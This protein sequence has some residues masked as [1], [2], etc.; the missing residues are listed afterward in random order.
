MGARPGATGAQVLCS[1]QRVFEPCGESTLPAGGLRLCGALRMAPE[2]IRKRRLPAS[3][4]VPRTE[5][6]GHGTQHDDLS[7]LFDDQFPW[8]TVAQGKSS[9]PGKFTEITY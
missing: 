2:Y 9:C 8:G 3:T 1:R 6:S 7:P 5:E 4:R